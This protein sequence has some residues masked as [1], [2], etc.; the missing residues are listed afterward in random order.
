MYADA[1]STQT[2]LQPAILALQQKAA[3]LSF[4]LLSNLQHHSACTCLLKVSPLLKSF[5]IQGPSSPKA[6]DVAR[7]C[8]VIH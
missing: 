7:E 1:A 2:Q 6:A 4:Q 5:L 3:D 8:N